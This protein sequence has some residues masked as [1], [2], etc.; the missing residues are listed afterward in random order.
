MPSSANKMRRGALL[1]AGT[2]SMYVSAAGAAATANIILPLGPG[3]PIAAS[4]INAKPEATIYALGCGANFPAQVDGIPKEE[5]CPS[6]AALTVTQGPSTLVYATSTNFGELGA[7][8][9][10]VKANLNC[11]FS[12]TTQAICVDS[13]DGIE[14]VTAPAGLDPDQLS[15]FQR[16]IEAHKVPE[17]VT[18]VGDNMPPMGP[19]QITAGAEKM[20]SPASVSASATGSGHGAGHAGMDGMDMATTEVTSTVAITTTLGKTAAHTGHDMDMNMSTDTDTGLATL[21]TNPAGGGVN[22]SAATTSSTRKYSFC[23][24]ASQLLLIFLISCIYHPYWR[25]NS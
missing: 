16:N 15:R 21:E 13:F 19:V 20:G 4:I 11:K 25:C 8:P 14:K 7:A 6:L 3:V 5:I 10:M 2:L 12:G 23:D 22:T 1:L 24:Q 18:L 9:T 17:T